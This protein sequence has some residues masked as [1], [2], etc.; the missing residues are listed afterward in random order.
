[1]VL[2]VMDDSSNKFDD[3]NFSNNSGWIHFK[4]I[5]SYR[6]FLGMGIGRIVV[7]SF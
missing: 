4:N 1:M 6:K 5:I 7:K 2:A 3:N